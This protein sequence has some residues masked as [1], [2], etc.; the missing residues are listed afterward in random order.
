MKILS[1]SDTVVPSI[2]SPIIRE[3]FTGVDC[4][5]GCG[6]LPYYYQEYIISSLNVPLFFVHGNHDSEVEYSDH[7]ECSYP[8][9][10][11]NLHQKIIR[12]DG[13]LIAGVQGSI[14][15]SNSSP[16]QYTQSQMWWSVI[17]LVPGMMWNQLF[18]GRFL[19]VFA[20]HAPPWGIHDGPDYPH[21]GIKAFRWLLQVF[22]PQVHIH[23]HIHVYQPTAIT[24][25]QFGG[26]S[27]VNTYGYKVIEVETDKA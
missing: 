1:I 15:Y 27:V 7:G 23:G 18:Y 14:R 12:N 8:H 10:G 3:K 19:D 21:I 24:E 20:T 2:Y 22:K 5:I 11:T 26:T 9:G 4:V 6:D 13:L 16:F 25:T 17:K